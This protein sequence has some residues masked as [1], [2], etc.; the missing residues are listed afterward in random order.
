MSNIEFDIKCINPNPEAG[1]CGPGGGGFA[2]A[3]PNTYQVSPGSLLS[4]QETIDTAAVVASI[5]TPAVVALCPGTYTENIV[6]ADNVHITS[7]SPAN[8]INS[9]GRTAITTIVGSVSDGGDAVTSSL[10]QLKISGEVLASSTGTILEINNSL[11]SIGATGGVTSRGLVFIRNSVGDR[12]SGPMIHRV[13]ATGGFGARLVWTGGEIGQVQGSDSPNNFILTS[14][15]VDGL[16]R[17]DLY[18]VR[19]RGKFTSVIGPSSTNPRTG[20]F[21]VNSD[22][23]YPSTNG[24]PTGTIF[25]FNT[26]TVA[27]RIDGLLLSNSSIDVVPGGAN[28]TVAPKVPIVTTTG[29]GG[30][31]PR[32]DLT[33]SGVVVGSTTPAATIWDTG[34][35]TTVTTHVNF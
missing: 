10:T 35:Q 21:V 14:G 19:H 11:L 27:S 28:P 5:G 4:I 6:L 34:V 18:N 2:E 25:D 31:L 15:D 12:Q 7:S 1:I 29:G 16:A 22:L 20:I 24:A 26:S 17:L 13:S 32:V 23:R 30:F 3:C 9:E 33:S 8:F